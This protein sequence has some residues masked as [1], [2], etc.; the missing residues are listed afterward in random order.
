MSLGRDSNFD[1]DQRG[2][3]AVNIAYAGDRSTHIWDDDTRHERFA[4]RMPRLS[5]KRDCRMRSLI[6]RH[7]LSYSVGGTLLWLL[8]VN[9]CAGN[10]TAVQPGLGSAAACIPP[11]LDAAPTGVVQVLHLS[12]AQASKW[13]SQPCIRWDA[14]A[15]S[16]LDLIVG[17][18]PAAD[19]AATLSRLGDISKFK[20]MRYW[21]VTDGRLEYLVVNASA[22]DPPTLGGNRRHDYTS[23][24]IAAMQVGDTMYFEEI[25]NRSSDGMEYRLKFI[26][27]DAA[28]LVIE[29]ANI[30]P[31]RIHRLTLFA[32]GALRTTLFLSSQSDGIWTC[33]GIL[34]SALSPIA[35]MMPSHKSQINRLV[36]LYGY[37]TDTEP[38]Y[39]PWAH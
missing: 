15:L 20:G 32:P 11:T 29:I 10:E 24:E 27:R 37:I 31:V 33:Y 8:F 7:A 28:H 18:Y 17:T 9:V 36:A 34:G 30:S 19:A 14:E 25:D 1:P 3:L 26:E 39:L 13:A 5:P 35:R 23:A 22:L 2:T 21:S 38:Q 16:S 6:N 4:G 12:S